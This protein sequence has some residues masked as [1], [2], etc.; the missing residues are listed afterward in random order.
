M[1]LKDSLAVSVASAALLL[2]FWSAVRSRFDRRQ[3]HLRAVRDQLTNVLL[4]IS[5]TR[6][7]RR[8]K[9]DAPGDSPEVARTKYLD[10]AALK[11]RLRFLCHQ[12]T[13]LSSQ[14]P[15]QVASI[16]YALIA[17]AFEDYGE[18]EAAEDLHRLAVNSATTGKDR[19]LSLRSLGRLELFAR[20]I[21]NAR[22]TMTMAEKYFANLGTDDAR[23]EQVETLLRWAEAESI[24]GQ[25]ESDVN[26]LV[27]RA[28][29]AAKSIKNASR[30]TKMLSL[31]SCRSEVLRLH[32]AQGSLLADTL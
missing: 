21:T 24:I 30:R 19:A 25:P 22:K 9:E 32:S 29:Q 18:L 4:K 7:A 26:N 23:S 31:V 20:R 27:E 8:D 17:L 3:D 11:D 12:A 1:T 2:S 6:L 10:R 16:E 5:D 28:S 15:A 14:I 13:F